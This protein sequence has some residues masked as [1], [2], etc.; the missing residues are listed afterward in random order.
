PV[1]FNT[2]ETKLLCQDLG[3]PTPIA[4]FKRLLQ[5][6]PGPKWF[7]R[8]TKHEEMF[9]MLDFKNGSA[10]PIGALSQM[11]G[12][13][14]CSFIPSPGFRYGFHAANTTW[15]FDLI[16][17]CDLEKDSLTVIHPGGEPLCWWDAQNILVRTSQHEL[18]LFDVATERT[19]LLYSVETISHTLRSLG[20]T[21]DPARLG[22]LCGW[23]GSGYRTCLT[24][25]E[26]LGWGQSFLIEADPATQSLQ[27][28]D[29]NFKFQWR[30]CLD[31]GLTR[32]LYDGEGGVPGRGGN[33]AV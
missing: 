14:R 19:N 11:P 33:G 12:M 32:Y 13:G 26:Q 1:L 28:I 18:V 7:P 6:L 22:I 15:A 2:D 29:R 4:R 5:K 8:N 3:N 20:L 16:F 10:H 21:N 25:Q 27:L 23:V 24:E 31:A 17:L 9:W 30:G